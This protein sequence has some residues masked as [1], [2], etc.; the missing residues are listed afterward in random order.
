M[1]L[2]WPLILFTAFIAWSA[3][4][5]ATQCIYAL[6]GKAPKAQMVSL[7]T[8]VVLLAI[9]GIAVF[10]HLQ[11]WTRI[12]NGFGHLTSGITQELI[13]IV[14]IVIVM[15]VYFAY[16]RRSGDEAKVPKWLAI[17]GIVVSVA[18]VCVMG[19]SYVM[20]SRPAWD[21]VLQIGSLVG[22]ACALGPASFAIIAEIRGNQ[23]SEAHGLIAII[24]QGINV[25][26]TAAYLV[27]M[28]LSTN[29]L[30]YVAY[31]YDPTSPTQDITEAENLS[32]FGGD[33]LVYTIIVIIGLVI[34]VAAA[35]VG[36]KTGKWKIF[37]GI[38]VAGALVAA[39]CLRCV[40]YV[41]GV[42]VYP[43]FT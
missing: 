1:E 25:V 35:I 42:S 9:G 24:G 33:A 12:F 41:M 11:H 5:F 3:G 10:F 26:L 28:Q 40:F 13:G 14:V 19:H 22:A 16:L 17:V 27:A 20:P 6:R 8:S 43:F 23:D 38:A 4:L 7:F 15:V 30:T 2:Q 39:L 21:S 36:K 34:G 37:G 18:L 29:A 31:W 32:V